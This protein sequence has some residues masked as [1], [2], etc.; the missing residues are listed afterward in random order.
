MPVF[1]LL[2]IDGHPGMVFPGEFRILM[3]LQGRN[4]Q[5]FLYFE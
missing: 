4:F 2:E 3:A 5:K 1:G